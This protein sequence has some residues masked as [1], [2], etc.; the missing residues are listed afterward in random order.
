MCGRFVSASPP[1]ELAQYFGAQAPDQ[2]LEPNFNVAPTREVYAVRADEGHRKLTTMRWGL[3]PFWAKDLKIGAKMINARSE[4]LEQKPSFRPLLEANR[5]AIM[6]SGFYEWE[7]E[8]KSKTPYKVE[9]TDGTP[10]I[11]AGLWTHNQSL[12][13]SSYA[14]LTSAAPTLF[15]HIHHR[16]PVILEPEQVSPWLEGNWAEA[17]S[18]ANT[19]KGSLT[20]TEIS[21]AVN[22]NRNNG[23]ELLAPAPTRL[24]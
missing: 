18:L 13:Y 3:V 2:E 20:A 4:T 7:R 22:S 23:P 6:I 17:Q 10:M 21:S 8:G 9:R 1:D 14:V 12:D 15:A 11:M 16:C 5:C 24:L 19:Y